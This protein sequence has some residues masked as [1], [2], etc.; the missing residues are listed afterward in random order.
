[1]HRN[2]QG[3]DVFAPFGRRAEDWAD[4]QPIQTKRRASWPLLF[5][6]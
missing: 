3:D 4:E 2:N 5:Y 6:S 1:M